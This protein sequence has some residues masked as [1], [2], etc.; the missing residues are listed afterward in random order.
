MDP[1]RPNY[2]RTVQWTMQGLTEPFFN[3][4]GSCNFTEVKSCEVF[5]WTRGYSSK[6]K[7]C[8]QL[9]ALSGP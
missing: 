8:L 3:V 7:Q 6:T 1:K 9:N 5:Y 2:Q 4:V